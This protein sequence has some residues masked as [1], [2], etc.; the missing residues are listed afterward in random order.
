VRRRDFLKGTACLGGA[1][2][3]SHLMEAELP[4]TMRMPII[5]T[6]IHL[7]DTGRPGGVPWPLESDSTIYKPALPERYKAISAGLGVAGAIAIEASPLPSDNDW[8]LGVAAKNPI[9]IGIIG[10]LIPGSPT[11]AKELDRL[12]RNPLFLGIRYG[13]LWDRDLS[14]DIGKPGF[15]DGLKALAQ[16]G[17]VLESANPD[18][19]LIAALVTVASHIPTLTIIVDHLPHAPVPVD[20]SMRATYLSHLQELGHSPHVFVKM[21][22]ILTE[23]NGSVATDR[24]VYKEG[25]DRI[26]DIFGED[27]ILYGS[28]WPNSDHLASYADT[29]TVAKNYVNTKGPPAAEKFFWK[30]SLTAYHWRQREPNQPLLP[31]ES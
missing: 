19:K 18:P 26:W 22:E 8:V 10:N 31:P 4:A 20:P 1:L 9:I 17:L 12:H 30:N 7:Y 28:D 23:T 27:R 6:H 29:F 16:T 3:A 2:A 14:V 15:L 5:D 24:A 11:Y 21:S 13:N 25:L